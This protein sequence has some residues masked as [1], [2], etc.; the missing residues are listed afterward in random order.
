MKP[1]V[2]IDLSKTQKYI[3]WLKTKLFLDSISDKSKTRLVKRGQVYWCHFGYNIGSE[4]S[5]S[6]ERPAIIIQKDYINS[7]SP[8]TIVVPVTHDTSKLSCLIPLNPQLD[9]DSNIV[10]DGSANISNIVCISKARLGDYI[11]TVSNIELKTIDEQIAKQLDIFSYYSKVKKTLD[12]ERKYI[13]TLKT[14]NNSLKKDIEKFKS[15]IE[16][17]QSQI[18]KLQ[19]S[20]DTGKKT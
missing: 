6:T 19:Q 7:K 8:N 16:N 5:K 15:E 11:S 12:S 10:L 20:L 4:M 18:E 1:L 2:K 9:A 13:Q 17:Y 14:E 3:E